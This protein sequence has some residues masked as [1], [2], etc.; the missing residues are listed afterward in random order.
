[1]NSTVQLSHIVG[2]PIIVL[3]TAALV[4]Y[5]SGVNFCSN[6]KKAKNIIIQSD[7]SSQASQKYIDIKYI[8][9]FE[10]HAIVIKYDN[11]ITFAWNTKLVNLYY[12]L[13]ASVYT[14]QG[15][16]IGTLTDIYFD[17]NTVHNIEID[18]KK[19]DTKNIVSVSNQILITCDSE[20]KLN[21]KNKKI[22]IP[23]DTDIAKNQQVFCHAKTSFLDKN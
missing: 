1:M 9:N 7:N 22:A 10:H 14:Q 2:K 6:L 19:T 23:K 8:Y 17:K 4:G 18:G 12:P 15:K 20:P 16:N 21:L 5:A 3:S 13:N 11:N